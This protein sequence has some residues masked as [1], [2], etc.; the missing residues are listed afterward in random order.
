MT[1]EK[2]AEVTNF[3]ES[4]IPILME[5]IRH[6]CNSAAT[7]RYTDIEPTATNVAEGEIVVYDT[8]EGTTGV[9]LITGK[10]NLL[11]L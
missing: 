2:P 5:I 7:I 1:I 11:E 4:N 8:G 3:D 10:G 6:I 9:F